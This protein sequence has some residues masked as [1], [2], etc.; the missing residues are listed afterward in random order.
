MQWDCE[1]EPF[2]FVTFLFF[3]KLFTYVNC[4]HMS[5]QASYTYYININPFPDKFFF[6]NPYLMNL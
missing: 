2:A 1:D 3:H 4:L 5:M 6:K